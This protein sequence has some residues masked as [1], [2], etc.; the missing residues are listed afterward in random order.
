[1]P[2]VDSRLFE[3]PQLKRETL[4]AG[5]N[6]CCWR[7]ADQHLAPDSERLLRLFAPTAVRFAAQP[8]RAASTATRWR[9]W[10]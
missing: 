3:S 5:A 8:G 2:N 4:D 6:A 1:M 7:A 10:A 9:H